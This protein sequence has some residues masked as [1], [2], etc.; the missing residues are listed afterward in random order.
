[1][2]GTA[3][4][5]LFDLCIFRRVQPRLLDRRTPPEELAALRRRDVAAELR[6]A[7]AAPAP[8]S[9][10]LGEELADSRV[11]LTYRPAILAPS[12]ATGRL[13]GN[14]ERGRPGV[15]LLHGWLQPSY[16]TLSETAALLSRRGLLVLV[17]EL[18]HHL[19]RR[20]PGEAH[21]ARFVS[22]DLG[23]T[24]AAFLQALGEAAAAAAWLR[25]NTSGVCTAGFSL[26]GL[27]AGLHACL[28]QEPPERVLLVAPAARPAETLLRSSLAARISRSLSA[29]GVAPGEIRHFLA[30]FDLTRLRPRVPPPDILLIAPRG[31]RAVP[32]SVMRGLRDGWG[33]RWRE[34]SAGHLSLWL[35][36]LAGERLGIGRGL[37]WC[38]KAADFLAG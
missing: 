21:G 25:D 22:G 38:R 5:S 8:D 35:P 23:L 36:L 16:L 15:L 1:M 7:A 32:L 9:V 19:S 17:L 26:G 34:V 18:P 20:P 12:G 14:I 37:S 28:A 13:Y 27:L 10:T 33:C 4:G 3:L 29:Q 31:D 24:L 6:S 11:G 30:P 2:I